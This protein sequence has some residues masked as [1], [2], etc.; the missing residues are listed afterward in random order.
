MRNLASPDI[1]VVAPGMNGRSWALVITLAV[2]S[3]SVLV[4][5]LVNREFRG[6]FCEAFS[7][8]NGAPYR[9]ELCNIFKNIRIC[10]GNTDVSRFVCNAYER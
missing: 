7:D 9:K 3:M 1:E 2:L 10:H 4:P 6:L 8:V 5:F